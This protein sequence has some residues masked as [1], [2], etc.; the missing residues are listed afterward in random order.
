MT[1]APH[2]DGSETQVDIE[3]DFETSGIGRLFGLLARRS[4]RH[5]VVADGE[6][7]KQRLESTEGPTQP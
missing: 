3:I 7:L 1:L 2:E 6:H 5:D 4:A